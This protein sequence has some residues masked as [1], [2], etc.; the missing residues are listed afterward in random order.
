[1]EVS[2]RSA[3]SV[4]RTN[5]QRAFSHQRGEVVANESSAQRRTGFPEQSQHGI[6]EQYCDEDDHEDG[7]NAFPEQSGS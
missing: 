4:V 7:E 5:R 2:G 3:S 1:M 6:P